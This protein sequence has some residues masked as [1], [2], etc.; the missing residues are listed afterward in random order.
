PSSSYEW[1][2]NTLEEKIKNSSQIRIRKTNNLYLLNSIIS[3]NNAKYNLTDLNKYD[4]YIEGKTSNVFCYLESNKGFL[5]DK[6]NQEK[7]NSISKSVYNRDNVDKCNLVSGDENAMS[8]QEH[9]LPESDHS[10]LEKIDEES[11]DGQQSQPNEILGI[12]INNDSLNHDNFVSEDAYPSDK[13]GNSGIERKSIYHDNV[14]ID[15]DYLNNFN[16]NPSM[17]KIKKLDVDVKNVK[18]TMWN[19][20]KSVLKREGEV[21]NY[22]IASGSVGEVTK[23]AQKVKEIPSNK[24]SQEE[25]SITLKELISVTKDKIGKAD[26]N[27][28]CFGTSFLSILHIANE[29]GLTIGHKDDKSIKNGFITDIDDIYIKNP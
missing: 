18:K 8:V 1:N 10:I 23:A 16:Y 4:A 21:L 27:N 9:F 25:S 15:A 6:L 2:E 22:D 5:E 7:F 20:L 24:K 14:E 29:K 28:L 17:K 19:Y 13:A 12:P 11:I 26:A 3:E